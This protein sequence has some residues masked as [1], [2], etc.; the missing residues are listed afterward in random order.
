MRTRPNGRVRTVPPT[1]PPVP[2]G[3]IL[4]ERA[5]LVVIDDPFGSWEDAASETIRN[6]VYEWYRNTV[7]S[8]LKPGGRIVL[9]HQRLHLDDLAGRLLA[10]EGDEWEVLF[11]PAVWEGLNWRGEFQETDEL[12]RTLGQS[13]WPEY[14]TEEFLAEKQKNV[15]ALGWASMYQ[16]RPTPVGGT[17][18]RPALIGRVE[19][20]AAEPLKIVRAWDIASTAPKGGNDPDWTV[21]IK[22]QRNRNGTYT[23]LDIV[24]FRGGPEEVRDRIV[25]TAAADAEQHGPGRVQISLPQDPGAAGK[26]VISD[27]TKALAGHIVTA[28]PESGDKYTRAMPFAAQVNAGNVNIVTSPDGSTHYVRAYVEELEL[29][30][31]GKK[32]DQV[33]ASSRAFANLLELPTQRKPARWGHSN[34]MAR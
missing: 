11:L 25:A 34:H 10:E 14:F 28:S 20:A 32:D 24:R 30:P 13:V 7:M 18:F 22:M 6:K 17:L 23:I 26:Y 4:G 16:Q 8:R 31:A 15:G 12:G 21:G 19:A 3:G 5:D 27:L 33:D 9:M 29:F 1:G 2:G